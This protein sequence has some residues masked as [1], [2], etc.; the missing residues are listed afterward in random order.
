MK[1][2]R[3]L[4]ALEPLGAPVWETLA[5]TVRLR[6]R[7]GFLELRALLGGRD[8]WVG[9]QALGH[10]VTDDIY[11]ALEGLLHVDVILGAGFKKLKPWRKHTET[12]PSFHGSEAQWTQLWF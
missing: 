3:L 1:A 9:L 11:E 2:N 4:A 8:G 12:G 6:W 7:R 5:A 10:F